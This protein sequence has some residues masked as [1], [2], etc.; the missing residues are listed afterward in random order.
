MEKILILA[1]LILMMQN[2][3]AQIITTGDSSFKYRIKLVES[4]M[5]R[6]N[7]DTNMLPLF[8]QMMFGTNSKD[9]VEAEEFSKAAL[10]SGVKIQ[11]ADTNWF[12]IAPCTGKFKGKSID[13]MLILNVEKYDKDQYK[14]VV[15]K[16]QGEIFKLTPPDNNTM[17]TPLAHENNFMELGRIVSQSILNISQKNYHLDE[18]TVFFAL[19]NSGLLTIEYVSNLQFMFLQ[20]PGYVFIV[21]EFDRETKNS[22][23]LI[24][25]I[26]KKNDV[27]K[28][29]LLNDLYHKK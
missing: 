18:T 5:E 15:A 25:S 10:K 7:N 26:A 11:F 12:A 8:D 6:F 2:T 27:E 9:K 16:A 22:G 28:K 1:V 14:W 20:V 13:F 17:I 21:T 4:F 29:K 23:W 3:N 19:Y 24:N